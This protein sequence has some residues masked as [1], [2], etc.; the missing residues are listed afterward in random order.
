MSHRA[1]KTQI[2]NFGR[3]PVGQFSLDFN[4]ISD[5]GYFYLYLQHILGATKSGMYCDPLGG[6]A[7]VAGPLKNYFFCGFSY[8]LLFQIKSL[9][10]LWFYGK[11]RAAFELIYDFM[12][13][14]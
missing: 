2:L 12:T 14:V 8:I 9:L 4:K 1:Q 10:F 5:L 13:N 6:K 7:L 3:L 11:G